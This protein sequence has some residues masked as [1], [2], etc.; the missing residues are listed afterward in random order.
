MNT[1]SRMLQ[2]LQKWSKAGFGQSLSMRRSP[3]S[4]SFRPVMEQLDERVM[5]A[6]SAASPVAATPL[7]G[8]VQLQVTYPDQQTAVGTGALIDGTHVLTAA[9]LLYS[10]S[11]G[12]YAT[13]V[14]AIP[15]AIGTAATLPIAFASYERVDPSWIS[16]SNANPGMTS[17]SAEDI[18]L[19]TL[20]QSIGNSADYFS[21]GHIDNKS[22]L[23][24]ATFQTAGYPALTGSASSYLY[25]ETGDALGAASNDT[26]GFSQSSLPAVPGQSGSPVYQTEN[27]HSV[28]YGVLAGADGFAATD[29]VYAARI[30]SSINTEVKNWL[31]ADNAKHGASSSELQH[32]VV[33]DAQINARVAATPAIQALD[34]GWASNPNG[35]YN[36]NLYNQYWYD[37]SSVYNSLNYQP[38][39]GPQ[40]AQAPYYGSSANDFATLQYLQ[41]LYGYG[42]SPYS[43]GLYP[44]GA[45]DAAMPEYDW[46]ELPFTAW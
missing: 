37:P 34:V 30:T 23:K 33:T 42:T 17:A 6:V 25:S 8:V 11:D 43:M 31:K 24:G 12:G 9:H 27:G 44:G 19:V 35:W 22:A 26:I 13:S 46:N 29:T 3:V 39:Y 38:Y 4:K 32:P 14:E 5:P 15:P 10:A 21:I 18:G 28:I 40:F 7:M 16:F 20:S 41:D 36:T 2:R 45:S 1:I